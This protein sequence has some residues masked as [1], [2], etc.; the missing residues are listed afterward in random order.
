MR[1]ITTTRLRDLT[2]P[3][4]ADVRRLVDV[5]VETVEHARW[6]S[7]RELRATFKTADRVRIG[8]D[9]EVY[10]FNIKGNSYRLIAGVAY[11]WKE[12]NGTVYIKMFMTHAQYSKGQWKERLKND[13]A[14]RQP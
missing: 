14:N 9:R 11:C 13:D 6:H 2:R 8:K 3:H 12:T 7:F 5:W 1:V 10:V 4:P